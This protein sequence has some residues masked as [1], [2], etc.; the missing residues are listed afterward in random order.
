MD[1]AYCLMIDH[2]GNVKQC[3]NDKANVLCEMHLAPED[4]QLCLDKTIAE[5]SIT[6][7]SSTEIT[8]QVGYFPQNFPSI[9]ST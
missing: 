5:A 9:K 2:T 3:V 4:R 8:M 6:F 7:D 1:I